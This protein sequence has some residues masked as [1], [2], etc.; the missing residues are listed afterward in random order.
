MGKYSYHYVGNA[1]FS[2]CTEMMGRTMGFNEKMRD[3]KEIVNGF[4]YLGDRLIASGGCEAAV[5]ARV[6]SGENQE[7]RRVIA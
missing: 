1:F 5:K 4:C 3:E 7:M 2:R 6:R